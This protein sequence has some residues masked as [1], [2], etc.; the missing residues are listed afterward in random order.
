MKRIFLI[1]LT[2]LFVFP[3][4]VQAAPKLES[5]NNASE[6]R[7]KAQIIWKLSGLGKP[8]EQVLRLPD[9]RLLILTGNKMLCVNQQGQLLWEAKAGSGK[10][11]NPVLVGNG[12]IFT[13]GK[14]MVAETKINGVSGWSFTALPGGKDKEPQMA[15]GPNNIIYLPLPYA[16]YAL[17][18]KGHAVW[19]FS[20]WDN[21]DRFTVKVPAKRTFMTCAADEQAFYVVYADEK[22]SYKLIAIDAKG[23]QLWTY[24]LGDVLDA[25]I[26][27]GGNDKVYVTAALKPSQRQGGGKS[28]SGKL[29][30]GRIYCFAASE[31]KRPLWQ[32]NV[33]ISDSLTAPVLA[34]DLLYLSGGSSL[35]ALDANTGILKLENRLL[36]LVSPP[37]VDTV[38]GSI[39]AG[40]SKGLFYAVNSSGRLDWS[41]ELEGAIEQAPV[42][43]S[44]GFIYVCTQK[45]NL[46]KIRDNASGKG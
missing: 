6:T 19:T 43:S 26:V 40:S 9:D 44:D 15:G 42:L 27:P 8:S 28:T 45:G 13:A 21:S 10:I 33:K 17:D 20:P 1:V 46:Y 23:K 4:V 35:Y 38:K 3:S 25:H 29:N 2:I 12:S 36:N 30:Q 7:Q 14:G 34:G 39:Y 16:L 5:Y 37:A 31:G 32:Y 11:G 22:G 24:W 18:T 41:R